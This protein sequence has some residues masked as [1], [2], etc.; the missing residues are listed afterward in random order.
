MLR[1][2]FVAIG[3]T[4]L[5]LVE[6][7]DTRWKLFQ[8]SLVLNQTSKTKSGT[9]AVG[10]DEDRGKV[11]GDDLAQSVQRTFDS[12][13]IE[14]VVNRFEKFGIDR[15]KIADTQYFW[16]SGQPPSLPMVVKCPMELYA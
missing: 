4:L 3:I 7:R 10:H 6:D 2:L 13:D 16:L 1:S 9:I 11:T 5:I 12:N 15:F 8:N 14:F